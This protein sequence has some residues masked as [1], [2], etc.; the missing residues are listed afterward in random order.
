MYFY[1]FLKVKSSNLTGLRSINHFRTCRNIW[2]LFCWFAE[3]R[4]TCIFSK[5]CILPCSFTST[6]GDVQIQW[7]QQEALIFSVQPAGQRFNHGNMFL[8][9]DSVSEG[10]ASLLVKQVD[11]RSKGRY[12][13]VV[14]NVTVTYVVATVEGLFLLQE[15]FDLFKMYYLWLVKHKPQYIIGKSLWQWRLPDSSFPW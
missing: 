1:F 14:N 8:F 3:V 9:S 13:C 12:K 4:V 5:D 10:N 7:F 6:N 2:K 11:T 15:Y